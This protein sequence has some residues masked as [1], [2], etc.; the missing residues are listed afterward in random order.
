MLASHFF[1]LQAIRKKISAG[2]LNMKPRQEQR[3]QSCGRGAPTA[4]L[5]GTPP[6]SQ[7]R[8]ILALVGAEKTQ[9]PKPT[10]GSVLLRM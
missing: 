2:G 1:R 6:I 4:L 7:T 5:P 10:R 9:P 3:V 8:E